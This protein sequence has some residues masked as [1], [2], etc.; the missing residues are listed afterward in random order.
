MT[1]SAIKS[2]DRVLDVLELL[3]RRGNSASHSEIAYTLDIPKSSLSALLKNLVNRNYLEK[4][5]SANT[6]HLG[7]AF[8]A[9]SKQ[10]KTAKNILKIAKI[11][12]GWLTEKTKEASAFYLFK[13]DH[14]ERV[15]GEEASYPLSYRMTP[16]VQFTLYA[17]AAGKAILNC[18]SESEKVTYFKKTPIKALT[19]QTA[20][21]ESAIRKKIMV[22]TK[23]NVTIS[24]GENS[25]GVIALA[26]P[27][28]REDQAPI[29]ALRIVVPEVRF[30]TNLEK[31]C[32]ESLITAAK[33]VDYE[34]QT[35]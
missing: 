15:L 29:G 31:L 21:T 6:Y 18:L 19:N 11:Q 8:F 28:L 16:N 4:N 35:I 2:A 9:L 10:G 1:D 25:F 5:L 14:I 30:N 22:D 24:Y 33:K 3:C 7:A 20:T 13:G 23:N 32:R 17:A 26:I 12:L 34:L 27:L